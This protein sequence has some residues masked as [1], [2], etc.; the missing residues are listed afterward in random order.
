MQFRQNRQGDEAVPARGALEDRAEGRA[1]NGEPPH[2]PAAKENQDARHGEI[3]CTHGEH[4]PGQRQGRYLGANESQGE[5]G[6]K[7][8]PVA[9]KLDPMPHLGGNDAAPAQHKTEG[10]QNKDREQAFEGNKHQAGRES[11]ADCRI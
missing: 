5:Q 6:G 8:D 9:E 3:S 1:A 10:H 7:E 4:D 2:D 11:R